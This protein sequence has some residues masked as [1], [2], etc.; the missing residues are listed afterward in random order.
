[1]ICSLVA[2][3]WSTSSYANYGPYAIDSGE[4]LRVPSFVSCNPNYLTS[5]DGRVS[6]YTREKNRLNLTLNTSYETTEHFNAS[7]KDTD[8]LIE[9]FRLNG[10]AFT[11]SDWTLIERKKGVLKDSVFVT[12]WICSETDKTPL[13][14]WKVKPNYE[15]NS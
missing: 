12:I 10:G 7:F 4:R 13:L 6:S 2:L 5:W 11:E 15:S 9:M 14:D 8:E 3:I 1:M